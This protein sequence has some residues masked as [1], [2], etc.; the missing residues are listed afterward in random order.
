MKRFSIVAFITLLFLSLATPGFAQ[1]PVSLQDLSIKLW[2]EFDDPRLLVIIDGKLLQSEPD[3]VVPVPSGAFINAVASQQEDGRMLNIAWESGTGASGNDIIT[4]HPQGQHF[5]IEYYVPLTIKDDERVIDFELP[6]NTF[7]AANAVIEVL[8]PPESSDIV[9]DPPADI[10]QQTA[11]GAWLYQVSLETV[12]AE[13]IIH[14]RLS[15]RN[16]TGA[17]TMPETPKEPAANAPTP[18]PVQA[19]AATP[20]QGPDWLLIGLAAAAVVL[21]A[22]GGYGLWR[23]SRPVPEPVTPPESRTG[24]R[25]HKSRKQ[26]STAPAGKDRYCRN[27][28]TPFLPDD[29]FCRKCG[30][31]RR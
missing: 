11:D 26:A 12:T 27:C 10:S 13:Q 14:Q 6:A 3:V 30:A 2:P 7:N 15:Y 18:A 17:L 8:L 16:P 22:L 1:G 23:T 29:R 25:K 9:L 20:G 24:K 28:G 31:K 5:R 21:I 19:P 4:V